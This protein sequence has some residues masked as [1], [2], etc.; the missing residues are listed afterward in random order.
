MKKENSKATENPLAVLLSDKAPKAAFGKPCAVQRIIDGLPKEYAAALDAQMSTSF[1]DG[2]P[3]T[4]DIYKRMTLAGFQTSPTA[5]DRHR[6]NRC[7]CLKGN[8]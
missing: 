8:N 2:G 7:V 6:G 3:T 4:F 5:I 1:R